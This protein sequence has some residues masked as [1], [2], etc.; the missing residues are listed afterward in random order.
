MW[1]VG[2][3][4]LHKSIAELLKLKTTSTPCSSGE[5]GN[6]S[7][8]IGTISTKSPVPSEDDDL[9]SERQATTLTKAKRILAY[10]LR[11]VRVA[12]LQVH[13]RCPGRIKISTP[14]KETMDLS[15]TILTAKELKCAE[16]VLLRHYQQTRIKP[17][18]LQKLCKLNVQS[19]S[20]GIMRCYGRLGKSEMGNE[21]KY[22]ILVLRKTLLSQL[23]IQETHLCGHPGINHTMSIIRQKFWIPQLRAK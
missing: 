21:A 1:W 3:S 18:L 5:E 17:A 2:P 14:F 12:T 15:T 10:V 16:K 4:F 6:E 11:F 8:E 20:E 19:D 23:I 22:P 13:T 9:V 7:F